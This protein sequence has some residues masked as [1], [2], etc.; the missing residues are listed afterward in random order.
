MADRFTHLLDTSVYC[1][2]IKN[3]AHEAALRRWS[4]LDERRICISAICHFE[5][6][7][8]LMLRDS[9]RY[10]AR[11]RALLDGRYRILPFDEA[12]ARE[13]A[14]LQVQ[15]RAK[16]ATKPLADLV[17]A[18]TARQHGLTVA[19]LNGCDFEGI[20]GVVVEDWSR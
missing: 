2:P 7:Q 10:W 11:Y 9:D 3:H 14:E 20:P 6:L 19:T 12:T 17:I 4:R 8:G 1:Q 18:A 16:G 15:L 13:L 5:V